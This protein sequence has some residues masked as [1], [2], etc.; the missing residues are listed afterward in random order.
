MAVTEDSVDL[1]PSELDQNGVL[2]QTL[3]NA[4]KSIVPGT[5]Y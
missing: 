4:G 3:D 5:V 2:R 1:L